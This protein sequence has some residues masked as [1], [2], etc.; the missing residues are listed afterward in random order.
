MGDPARLT[1]IVVTYNS[2]TVIGDCLRSLAADAVD[3]ADVVVV[4]NAS[5]DDTLDVVEAVLPTATRLDLPDN[6]GYS[7][8][9]N[10]AVETSPGGDVLV[11]NPDIRL[12]R[13]TLA[14]LRRA[15]QGRTGVTVPR[16]LERDG[17]MSPSIRREPTAPRAWAEAVF[18]GRIAGRLGAGEMV[19]HPVAYQQR[20][21]VDWASGA[22]MYITADCLGAVGCFDESFFLYSEET[23]YMLRVRD[24]GFEVTYVPDAVAVHLGG[25]LSTSAELWSRRTVN[26]V[27][28]Q[29][30]RHGRMSTASFL[31]ASLAGEGVRA[32]AGRQISRRAAADLLRV[33]PRIIAAGPPPLEPHRDAV[34]AGSTARR[35]LVS[36]TGEAH[37]G[38]R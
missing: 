36:H 2:E 20:H 14:A 13:G 5:S 9:I 12:R 26:R 6:R 1:I 35:P 27:R 7:A 31:G 37:H 8:A 4:D 18:G 32:V 22:V 16:L 38:S 33:G 25:E 10:A 28:L 19:T 15:A 3:G 17:T 11:L 29:R 34:A 23:D 21:P 30:R 24:A